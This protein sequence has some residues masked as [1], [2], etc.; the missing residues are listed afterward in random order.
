MKRPPTAYENKLEIVISG[1][2]PARP[3]ASAAHWT[4]V[5]KQNKNLNF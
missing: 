3:Y 1:S 2:F 5:E 4:S